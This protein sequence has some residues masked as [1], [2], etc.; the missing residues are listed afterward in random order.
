MSDDPF[1]E[2]PIEESEPPRPE[3]GDEDGSGLPWGALIALVG[4]AITVVFA[5]QNT[6]P[7]PVT[8]LWMD[9]EYPL[10]L[11]ILITAAVTVLLTWLVG[12]AYRRRRK[13]RRA[14]QQELKRYREST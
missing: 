5:V 12:V 3:H 7:V 9:G 8:F 11:V 13:R 2:P 4:I 10:A 6:D 14:E 1:G